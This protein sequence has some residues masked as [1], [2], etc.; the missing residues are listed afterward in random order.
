MV[1]YCLISNTRNLPSTSVLYS[2]IA[3]SLGQSLNYSANDKQLVKCLGMVCAQELLAANTLTYD[4]GA[5]ISWPVFGR[6]F[7]PLTP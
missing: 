1:L 5:K 4:T 2:V 6:E 3:H 7:L